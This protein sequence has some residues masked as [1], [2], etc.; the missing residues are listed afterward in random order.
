MILSY[1]L[2]NVKNFSNSN[3]Y[4]NQHSTSIVNHSHGIGIELVYVLKGKALSIIED[5]KREVSE[6]DYFFVDCYT[7]HSYRRL[8]DDFCVIN[9]LFEPSFIDSSFTQCSSFNELC[10]L[11][12]VKNFNS[13]L[14]ETISNQI[15]IANKNTKE[16]FYKI[17]REYEQKKHGY[18]EIIRGAVREIIIRTMREVGDM[19]KISKITEYIIKEVNRRYK[20]PLTL[21]ALCA[22]LHFSPSY[23]STTFRC[24]TKCTFTQYL[25][26]TRIKE[27]CNML[28]YTE[29]SVTEI[30]EAVGYNSI[31]TFNSLFKSLTKTPPREYR[32]KNIK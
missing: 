11:Y 9:C 15:Y 14:N 6:G 29:L 22:E 12:A 31:K 7:H 26:M 1:P 16:L 3:F 17:R 13:H 27:A 30:A 24:D 5:N 25:Q 10:E 21:N 19:P 20:E 8:S 2:Y 18:A 4:V 23:A 32:K 28:I